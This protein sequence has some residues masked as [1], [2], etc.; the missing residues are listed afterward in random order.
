[1]SGKRIAILSKSI[2]LHAT[3]RLVEAARALGH[4]VEVIPIL[5][6]ALVSDGSAVAL[7]TNG[8]P[9]VRPDVVIARVGTF[10]TSLGLAALR[11]F[12]R[13]GV[14]CLNS[15]EA[16]EL[17]RDK[18]RSL[19]RLGQVGIAVPP[20]VFVKDLDQI[21]DA[22]AAVGGAPVIVK[23]ISGSQGQ[24]VVLAESLP[25]AVS[26]VEALLY[27][28]RDVL[29]QRFVAEA[30]GSDRRLLVVA[31]AVAA[32]VE[33]RALPGDFRSNHHQGAT[34][35]V[36][37]PDRSTVELALRAAEA[38]NMEVAAVDILPSDDGDVVLELN[39]SPGLD[40]IERATGLDLA[41]VIIEAAVARA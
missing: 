6:C 15:S 9:V 29:I 13:M 31:G 16:M 14:P 36:W 5:R 38:F 39:G 35:T 7:H 18:Q 25:S 20:T 21:E 12:E 4:V 41:S 1:M 34:T 26:I 2:E 33:R 32:S 11:A 27:L 40:G 3:A 19:E 22:V 24:G 37:D 8:A 30:E 23:P 10:M 28:N 17:S